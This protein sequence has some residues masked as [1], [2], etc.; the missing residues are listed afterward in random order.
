LLR[1]VSAKITDGDETVHVGGL[2]IGTTVENEADIELFGK[3]TGI[4]QY[5]GYVNADPG[6]TTG[7]IVHGEAKPHRR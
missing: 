5:E 7:S 3:A 2:S 4:M 6:G 1:I